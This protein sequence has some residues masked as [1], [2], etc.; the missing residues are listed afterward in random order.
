MVDWTSSALQSRLERVI[1]LFERFVPRFAESPNS[2]LRGA[3]AELLN[4][5]NGRWALTPKLSD[6]LSKLGQDNRARVRAKA[7]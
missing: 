1:A 4:E 3:V 2:I 6:V 5:I 7:H